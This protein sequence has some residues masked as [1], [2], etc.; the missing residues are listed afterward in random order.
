[1]ASPTDDD[2]LLEIERQRSPLLRGL[3]ILELLREHPASASE[4][5]RALDVNRSTAQRLL[6]QLES[7]GY[8][9]RAPGSRSYVLVRSPVAPVATTS[10]APGGDLVD[11]GD[12]GGVLHTVLREIRDEAG[13]STVFAVPATER[14]LYAAFYPTDHPVSVQE[15]IGSVRPMHASAVGKAY[16][17]ALPASNLDVVLGRLN[18]SEGTAR[19]AKGPF[20]L[21]EM[22]TEVQAHGYAVDHD[23]T[24]IGGSC[25]A[26]PV[27]VNHEILVG[28]AGITG[29]THR[30]A[31]RIED[32]G[33]M[34]VSRLSNIETR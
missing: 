3:Q 13:E 29:P 31:E 11:A 33:K 1:M 27:F 14:M 20:Q 26:T 28:A 22:L 10:H 34:V 25:V 8:V 21:R 4:A 18:F 2:E 24:F 5:A 19:A 12:W 23:E 32:Y 17:S 7:G 15:S 16:L 30:L 9:T 6:S